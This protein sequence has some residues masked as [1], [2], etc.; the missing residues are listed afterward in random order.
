M[1]GG[2]G[3]HLKVVITLAAIANTLISQGFSGAEKFCLKE[4]VG[5]R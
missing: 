1:E 2:G 4:M 3:S 5:L